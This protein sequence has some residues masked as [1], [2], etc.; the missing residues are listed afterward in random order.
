MRLE[1]EGRPEDA[2]ALY[3]Q[4]WDMSATDYDSMVAAHYL[5]R[6]TSPEESLR[7]N[8]VALEHAD[9]VDDARV[10]SFY[11]SLHFNIGRNLEELGDLTSAKEHFEAAAHYRAHLPANEY[12]EELNRHID[13]AL[14][15]IELGEPH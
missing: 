7:W 13:E 5:A 8:E 10:L 12:S 6:N 14:S 3:L 11:P 4:A 15:R 9:L 1:A 2:R